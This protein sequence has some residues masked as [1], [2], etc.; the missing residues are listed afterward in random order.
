MLGYQQ[1]LVYDSIK[2]YLIP[3][4]RGVIKDLETLVDH[5]AYGDWVC[6]V[7]GHVSRVELGWDAVK[8]QWYTIACDNYS[9]GMING[10]TRIQP[11]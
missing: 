2:G 4:L 3:S 8:S 5:D 10:L 9:N 6:F 1:S 11:S 7:M